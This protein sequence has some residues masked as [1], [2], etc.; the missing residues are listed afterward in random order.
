MTSYSSLQYYASNFLLDNTNHTHLSGAG[1]GQTLTTWLKD[2]YNANVGTTTDLF[3][4]VTQ[5]SKNSGYN[6][7]DSID[8]YVLDIENSP[9][10]NMKN[11]DDYEFHMYTQANNAVAGKMPTYSVSGPLIPKASIP[12]A[13]SIEQSS[14][15]FKSQE[16]VGKFLQIQNGFLLKG[17]SVDYYTV[18][19][20]G[21]DYVLYTITAPD[22]GTDYASGIKVPTDSNFGYIS[23]NENDV[24]TTV[25]NFVTGGGKMKVKD[26]E[27]EIK[28]ASNDQLISMYKQLVAEMQDLKEFTMTN[29]EILDLKAEIDNLTSDG[30]QGNLQRKIAKTQLE[31]QEVFLA[32]A[33]KLTGFQVIGNTANDT[34]KYGT[35]GVLGI[36]GI[37][38]DSSMAAAS[39]STAMQS[40]PVKT[41]G[42]YQYNWM[43]PHFEE[44]LYGGVWYGD[45]NTSVAVPVQGG[46][47]SVYMGQL[48]GQTTTA[49]PYDYV[50]NPFYQY[51]VA[52]R[53]NPD[54][55]FE[56]SMLEALPG[57]QSPTISKIGK[58]LPAAGFDPSKYT[59]VQ[60]NTEKIGV[61][62]VMGDL[63][64]TQE[65]LALYK[66]FEESQSKANSMQL[67]LN[68]A[69]QNS[70]EFDYR[71]AMA[72][73]ILAMLESKEP[74]IKIQLSSEIYKNNATQ[75]G[76]SSGPSTLKN[77]GSITPTFD[78]F[79]GDTNTKT[80][81]SSTTKC[82]VDP[83]VVTING[84]KYVIGRDNNSNKNIDDVS[85]ILGINDSQDNPFSSLVSL[86]ANKDGKV[87]Q[88]EM[89]ANGIV[90]KAVDASGKLTTTSYDNSLI[91]EIDLSTID[92]TPSGNSTGTFSVK[93][94]NGSKAQGV[95]TFDDQ[96]YFNKL[97]G[98]IVDLSAYQK[99]TTD[100]ASSTAESKST[101]TAASNTATSSTSLTHQKLLNQINSAYSALIVDDTSKID[102]I[103]NNICWKHSITLTAAQRNRI[104]DSIDPL[105]TPFEIEKKIV[106]AVSQLNLSA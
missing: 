81:S 65:L 63:Y 2:A 66:Q 38:D 61:F 85:E 53:T 16:D 82:G 41:V 20:W 44:W 37:F 43:K 59:N 90:F 45:G 17:E 3:D 79:Y 103:M 89:L 93:L 77:I 50:E 57:W 60:E 48:F 68:V 4:L 87:S 49:D 98:K 5:L 8:N 15:Y 30:V 34:S 25:N 76:C 14:S 54:L 31:F 70:A 78:G 13:F 42:S 55:T 39:G 51:M 33:K 75:R 19:E 11:E 74:A 106:N 22:Y 32:Q 10:G 35:N 96:A 84:T 7:L 52:L 56:K 69:L 28:T 18:D 91:S 62:D 104:V 80:T 1:S 71:K 101:E 83:Y 21:T 67:G 9:L 29:Q 100:S 47:N 102:T 92:K 27:I 58:D 73:K 24:A 86:D 88:A 99:T 12:P 6:P 23:S 26:T 64:A 94:S 97:F 40:V 72:D 46:G 36:R 95:Q 105:L